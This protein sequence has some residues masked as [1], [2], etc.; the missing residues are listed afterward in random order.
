VLDESME[1]VQH[2][3]HAEQRAYSFLSCSNEVDSFEN[4]SGLGY[5]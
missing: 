3:G 5:F 4:C 2:F 1:A